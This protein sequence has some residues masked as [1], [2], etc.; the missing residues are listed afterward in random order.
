MLCISIDVPCVDVPCVDASFGG[1]SSIDTKIWSISV[2]VVLESWPA[3]IPFV[4]A[5]TVFSAVSYAD[6]KLSSEV[7]WR[8]SGC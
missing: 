6:W 7:W 1:G 4:A 5:M 2:S 8:F 3:V